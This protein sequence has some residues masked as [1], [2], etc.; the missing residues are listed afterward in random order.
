VRRVEDFRDGL[1]VMHELSF[2]GRVTVVAVDEIREPLLPATA[3]QLTYQK[4]GF[5]V[6]ASSGGRSLLVLPV[7][8]SRCWTVF[9]EG[10]PKLIRANLMQ[11]GISFEGKLDANLVFRFGPIFAAQCRIDDIQDIERLHIREARD[12][13]N[14]NGGAKRP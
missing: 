4:T 11:L 8:Y 9:G 7:Q 14:E 2:D 10:D 5:S 13:K 3:V 1:R 6:Q 12:P